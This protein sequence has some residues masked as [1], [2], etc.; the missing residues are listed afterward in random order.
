MRTYHVELTYQHKGSK[1]YRCVDSTTKASS[2]GRAA[3]LAFQ[4]A[5]RNGNK[6]RESEGGQVLFKITI[7]AK[8]KRCPEVGELPPD[9]PELHPDSMPGLDCP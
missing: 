1:Y 9:D 5:K 7:G 2:A 4:A 3:H 8:E 6:I